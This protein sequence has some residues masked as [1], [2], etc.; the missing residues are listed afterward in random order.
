MRRSKSPSI[1]L[2]RCIY[3]CAWPGLFLLLNG[4]ERTRA[5]LAHG[6][7]IL[8]VRGW[9]DDAWSLPGGG[10]HRGEAILRGCLREI[11]EETGIALRQEQLT[12]AGQMPAREHGIS[13]VVHVYA[14]ELPKKPELS[15]QR[16]EIAELAWVDWHTLDQ[17]NAHGDVLDALRAWLA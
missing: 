11:R 13:F 8:V 12:F 17:G 15:R 14:A 9:L 10:L 4:S 1:L 6:D 2:G 5:I 3:W 16:H 7:E